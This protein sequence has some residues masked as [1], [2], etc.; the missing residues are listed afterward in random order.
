MLEYMLAS[1]FMRRHYAFTFS[2]LFVLLWK[3]SHSIRLAFHSAFNVRQYNCTDK[4]CVRHYSFFYQ[5]N[6]SVNKDPEIVQLPISQ[7]IFGD[8]I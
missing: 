3:R 6:S 4:I 5:Q 8:F 1:A 7:K 2:L